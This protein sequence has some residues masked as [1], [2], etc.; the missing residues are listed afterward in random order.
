LRSLVVPRGS[1]GSH[2]RDAIILH[3]SPDYG[4]LIE[5]ETT[6]VCVARSVYHKT[7]QTFADPDSTGPSQA[8]RERS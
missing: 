2:P 1:L 8:A 4:D 5:R 6:L 7:H 3:S